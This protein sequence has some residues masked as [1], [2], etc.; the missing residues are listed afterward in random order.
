MS[1]GLL[2]AINLVSFKPLPAKL[3][4]IVEFHTEQNIVYVWY[5]V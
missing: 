4:W 5:R 3:G 1:V 2:F